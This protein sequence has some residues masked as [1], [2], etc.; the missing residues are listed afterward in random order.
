MEKMWRSGGRGRAPSF[1]WLD[2]IEISAIQKKTADS[3]FIVKSLNP[4]NLI[5]L[6]NSV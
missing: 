2:R 3:K 4:K 6:F 5:R 1:S